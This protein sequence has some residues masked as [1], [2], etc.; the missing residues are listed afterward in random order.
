MNEGPRLRDIND[1]EGLRS[2]LE[3]LEVDVLHIG[4]FDLDATFR[5]RRL[6]RPYIEEA[7]RGS[8]SFVDVLHQWDSADR[9][10]D[11]VR[12]VLDDPV[13][14]DLSTLRVFPF[15]PHAG[16]LIADYSGRMRSRSPRQVLKTQIERA[17]TLGFDARAAF[18]FEFIVLEENAATLRDKGYGNLVPYPRDNRC[19]SGQTAGTHARFL[20]E[21]EDTL[22]KVDISLFGLGTELGPGC[23]EATLAATD[24]LRAADDAA[25]FKLYTK[26]FCRLRDLTASFMAQLSDSFP[27]LSGHVHL[28]LR[29][30]ESGNPLFWQESGENHMTPTMRHFIGGLLRLLPDSTALVAHTVNAY[31]RMVPGNWAPRTPT[32]GVGNYTTAVRALCSSPESTRLEFRIPAADT[33]PYLAL[34]VTLA[35][36]LWGIKNRIEPPPAVAGLA[37]NVRQQDTAPLPEGLATAV[38]RLEASD[39]LRTLLGPSFVDYFIASRHAEL[40]AFRSH[41]S[42][43]ERARYLEVV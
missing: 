10:H 18:E 42:A 23:F 11:D 35:T 33:N 25:F 34:A 38:R 27:G 15:E 24:A 16:L 6:R 29:D 39:T 31:R 20:A 21:L 5:E 17:A 1:T 19:W 37:R 26:V 4:I 32:W 41:V 22:R 3:A 36:G 9:V 7:L 2:A 30:R 40:S 8:Y 28:S 12:A 13:E 43:F 14:L